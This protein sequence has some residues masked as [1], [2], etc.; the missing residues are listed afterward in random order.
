MVKNIK[1]GK[2]HK[3][4]KN[5]P[6]NTDFN[7]NILITKDIENEDYGKINKILG[8]GWVDVKLNS[9][10]EILRCHISGKIRKRKLMVDDIVLI[11]IREFQKDRGDIIYKYSEQEI[12]QLRK[13]KLINLN[14]NNTIVGE[15]ECSN[16]IFS[17]DEI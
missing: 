8:N 10:Q 6:I 2:N 17:I 4:T 9:N 3:K 1:G 14:D 16:L 15:C 5:K 11:S 12:N 7:E 13:K